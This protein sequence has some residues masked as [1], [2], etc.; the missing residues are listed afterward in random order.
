MPE[1]SGL[2]DDVVSDPIAVQLP[3]DMPGLRVLDLRDAVLPWSSN[4]FTGLTELHLDYR[5]VFVSLVE[6]ELLRILET[7]PQLERLSLMRVG[8]TVPTGGDKQLHPKRI[9]GLPALIFLKLDND[10]K[11]VG[12]ILAHMDA[13]SC[14]PR[15]LF[16]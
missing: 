3:N 12:F 13:R 14:F 10:P 5:D 16:T 4:L 15:D 9:T 6:D 1:V 2:Y 11:V 8:E 7:S